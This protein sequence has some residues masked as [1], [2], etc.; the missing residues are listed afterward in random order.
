M[1]KKNAKKA[2]PK[3]AGRKTPVA[4]TRGLFEMFDPS[5]DHNALAGFLVADVQQ[6]DEPAQP[7]AFVF[8]P[9]IESPEWDWARQLAL[10]ILADPKEAARQNDRC[11]DLRPER[12]AT[13]IPAML[14][15]LH[16]ARI[17]PDKASERLG[18]PVPFTFG[19]PAAAERCRSLGVWTR[20]PATPPPP[21]K[22]GVP[23]GHLRNYCPELAEWD[24]SFP[25]RFSNAHRFE[26]REDLGDLK[27]GRLVATVTV[28]PAFAVK[29]AQQMAFLLSSAPNLWRKLRDIARF[30]I[31]EYETLDSFHEAVL[32]LHH[33][34]GRRPYDIPED[35]GDEKFYRRDM[36]IE[37]G[38]YSIPEITKGGA[39]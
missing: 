12:A 23:P 17:D 32:L 2:G 35:D 10:A 4:V 26:I 29:V 18:D 21:Y 20:D 37:G 16:A 11:I 30:E 19:K 34:S 28:D 33:A 13:P 36:Q 9:P 31:A 25:D 38:G 3:T 22:T 39:A 15:H 8:T 6:G 1:H 14:Y 5:A 27:H 24:V 7:I